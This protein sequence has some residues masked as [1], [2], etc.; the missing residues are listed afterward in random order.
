MCGG[1]GGH[2]APWEGAVELEVQKVGKH[3]QVIGCHAPLG[4]VDEAVA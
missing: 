1:W 3:K 4:V 2:E